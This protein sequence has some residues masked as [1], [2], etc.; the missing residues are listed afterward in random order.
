MHPARA[1]FP[2]LTAVAATALVF[3]AGTTASVAQ[4][5]RTSAAAP[6]TAKV[7]TFRS[8][9]GKLWEDHITW[10]R[11]FIISDLE[12]APDLQM[13][14]QRLLQNQVDI[15]D[16]IKPFYGN[17]A[18][19][20]L[21][22]LLRDHILIAADV[23]A[24]AKAGD[25]AR[26]H[27]QMARWQSNADDIGDYLGSLNPDNWPAASVKAMM[28]HHLELTTTEAVARLNQD[29]TG[30]IAAYDQVHLH[31]LTLADTLTSGIVTQFPEAFAD[32]T[33]AT[34][35]TDG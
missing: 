16:A 4:T 10:T 21:S 25:N 27:D 1:L 9:M 30:D 17:A 7:V 13:T 5:P 32:G 23:V 12:D 6:S 31:I 11:M 34:L 15:G 2:S 33:Q 22:A 3:W 35:Q 29:W 26:L 19:D 24:A 28:H 20:H 8:A 14:T 18:G